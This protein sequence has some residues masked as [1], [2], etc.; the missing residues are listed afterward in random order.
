MMKAKKVI[1]VLCALVLIMGILAACGGGNTNSGNT[2]NTSGSKSDGG[3]KNGGDNQTEESNE[4]FELTIMAN[5]HTPEVPPDTIKELIE[6]ATNTKL[7][8]QWTPD[9]NYDEK[10]NTAFAT[11]SMPQATFLR[12]INSL[13]LFKDAIRNDQFW[14]VGPLLDEYE[15]LSKLKDT[16]LQNTSVD[17]KIYGLYQ[18]RPLSRQGL[19]YRKDWAEKV[20]IT[21]PP[22]TT[23]ELMEMARAFTEDDP[24]NSGKDDTIGLADRADLTYGA[25]KTVSSWFGTPNNWGEKDGKLQPEFMFEGY[26]DTMDFI[27]DMR[28]N[29]YINQDF[30]VTSK[31]DQQSM[32][33]NGTSGMYI[34]SMGDVLSIYNDAVELNPD[35]LYDVQNRISADG[36]DEGVWSIPGYGT[37]VLFPKSAVE[38]EAELKQILSFF[39]KLMTPEVSNI[40]YW[41]VEGEHYNVSED[42]QFADT[43][44]FDQQV[45]DREVKPFQALEIGEPD[46]NGR[47]E[48]VFS[49]EVKGK[50]EELI[51][52]NENFL[53]NDPTAPLDSDTYNDKGA[54]IYEL[55][56]DATYQ[57]MVGDIDRAGFDK[58]V[59]NWRSQGGD[60]II[61]EFNTSWEAAK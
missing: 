58:A 14:E 53:I 61:D 31:T 30:P 51:K 21:S 43:S 38:D 50:A 47:Y 1:A 49:Y 54:S 56:K 36:V 7:T 35:V 23:E 46:T 55:I 44:G 34:G 3:N 17:G 40:L 4:P 5:L 29:G 10:L 22:S 9:G 6:E 59:K 39:D 11:S 42:G 18:G 8:I 28:D 26:V 12:N 2:K 57:Y 32:F 19:I 41:G 15:N 20:G 33:K 13:G 25:F 48:G 60:Q 16:V 52:D 45:K 37:V 27:R 24:N